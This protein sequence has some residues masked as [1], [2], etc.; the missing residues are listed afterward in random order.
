MNP[1]QATPQRMSLFQIPL[2]SQM[3]VLRLDQVFGV[4]ASGYMPANIKRCKRKL[5]FAESTTLN[6]DGDVDCQPSSS[7]KLYLEKRKSPDLSCDNV[8]SQS[9]TSKECFNK[10][11]FLDKTLD[12]KVAVIIFREYSKS[13]EQEVKIRAEYCLS[14]GHFKGKELKHEKMYLSPL[15]FSGEHMGDSERRLE[16]CNWF[17]NTLNDDR[18]LD[19]SF[20]FGRSMGDQQ[21]SPFQDSISVSINIP[22]RLNFL[23]THDSLESLNFH[24]SVL[25]S[26]HLVETP[27]SEAQQGESEPRLRRSYVGGYHTHSDELLLSTLES[28]SA[29]LN[30]A[31]SSKPERGVTSTRNI[32]PCA[33]QRPGK[34]PL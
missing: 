10:S 19:I 21:D 9:T 24:H 28:P 13:T 32:A 8:T 27:F 12:N 17:L 20:F 34:P 7:K 1:F 14:Q 33:V 5:K 22:S 11:S 3:G 31:T 2:M 30:H 25:Q 6:V 16:Y 29:P 26:H 4:L 23:N 15:I 18:L